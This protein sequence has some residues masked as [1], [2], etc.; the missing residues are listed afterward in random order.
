MQALST[1]YNVIFNATQSFSNVIFSWATS[2]ENN[3]TIYELEKSIDQNNWNGIN[4]F[5]PNNDIDNF[6]NYSFSEKISDANLNNFYRLKVTFT[7]NEIRYSEIISPE[8]IIEQIDFNLLFFRLF[9][10]R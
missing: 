5:Q 6:H 7:N 10:Y 1:E 4:N 8:K 2:K 3:I 9:N